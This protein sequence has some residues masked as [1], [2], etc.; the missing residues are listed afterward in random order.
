MFIFCHSNRNW[1]GK[2]R[3]FFLQIGEGTMIRVCKGYN[4][5][6]RVLINTKC[7]LIVNLLCNIVIVARFW[8]MAIIMR[9]SRGVRVM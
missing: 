2:A 4:E 7:C 6:V 9:V 1:S 8:V 3:K 5:G